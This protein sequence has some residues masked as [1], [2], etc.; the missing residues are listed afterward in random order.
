[1]C[2]SGTHMGGTI[3]SADIKQARKHIKHGYN[4]R[5]WAH[6][7]RTNDGPCP[8]AH[9]NVISVIHSVAHC[10][11]T[12]T[13]LPAFKLLQQSEIPRDCNSRRNMR[14]KILK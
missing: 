1:M 3:D 8:R 10:T 13:L 2:A 4:K 6:V 9:I 14:S 7:M 11:I 12:N 5:D